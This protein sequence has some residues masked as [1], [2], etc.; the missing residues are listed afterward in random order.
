MRHVLLII[1]VLS[2]FQCKERKDSPGQDISSVQPEKSDTFERLDPYTYRSIQTGILSDTIEIKAT[3]HHTGISIFKPRVE[4]LYV[5]KYIDGSIKTSVRDFQESTKDDLVEKQ[6]GIDQGWG[7]WIVPVCLYQDEKV[8]SY[9]IQVWS[10]YTGMPSGYEY[11]TINFDI[12]KNRQIGFD[13]FFI[14]KT[15]ADSSFW[16]DIISRSTG[17]N[18]K[19]DEVRR[20]LEWDD[21]FMFSFDKERIY[22]LFE[23]HGLLFPRQMGSVKRKYVA[24]HINERYR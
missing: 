12:E 19:Q 24:S 13:D 8:L 4:N 2:L 11:S 1:A 6:N 15:S 18:S 16:A 7:M 14:M 23:S 5:S 21:P 17:E 22:F 9:S 3:R 20:L 10:A